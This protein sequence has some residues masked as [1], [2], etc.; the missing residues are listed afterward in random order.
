MKNN[1]ASHDFFEMIRK[2]LTDFLPHVRNMSPHTIQAARDSLNLLL[3]YCLDICGIP[4]LKV[5]FS[6]IG[7]TTFIS[8]FLVWLRNERKCGDTTLN[9]RLSCLR[10]FFRY[11][12]YE[13]VTYVS[14]YQALLTI[15]QRKV[16]KNKTIEFLSE[17][18]LKTVLNSPKLNTRIGLRDAF[19]MTLI[20]D[21]AAR[22]SEMISLRVKDV[23]DEKAPY[24]FVYGKG[25]KRRSIPLMPKTMEMLR[26]YMKRF[27]DDNCRPDDYLFYTRHNGETF[28]MSADNVAKFVAQ[29][30]EQARHICPQVP[31]RVHPHMFRRS[32][33]MHL[34]RSGMPL[35]LLAEFLGHENPETT[36][37]YASADTEMKRKAIEK[38][39]AH[40]VLNEGVAP[41]PMWEN[42]DEMI[43][44]LYGLK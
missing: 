36:L 24:M 32:R 1:D 6:T 34:Y 18:A 16:P 19:Y 2:Y 33:A 20:Y 11:A 35:A 21:S 7:N 23:V 9:Q 17:E 5:N 42:D 15:P 13:D 22:N 29:Y 14:Q 27:H 44:R 12:A 8:D 30:A 10:G 3:D 25:R 38:A 37:I 39:S 28:Q 40:L 31:E 4:L 43:R 41:A 26:L